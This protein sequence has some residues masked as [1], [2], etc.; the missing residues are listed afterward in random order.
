MACAVWRAPPQPA[1]RPATVRALRPRVW[2][3]CQARLAR[4]R[5]AGNRWVP[6]H[7]FQP[8]ASGVVRLSMAG[9]SVALQPPLADNVLEASWK[10]M[11][12]TQMTTEEGS[13]FLEALCSIDLNDGPQ[14]RVAKNPMP[15]V[16]RHAV[17]FQELESR[18]GRGHQGMIAATLAP[19][20]FLPLAAGGP[21]CLCYDSVQQRAR[22]RWRRSARPDRQAEETRHRGLCQYG[23]R[24]VSASV[25]RSSSRYALCP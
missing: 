19:V 10:S 16:Q 25:V 7:G 9:R 5:A 15:C 23:G 2:A 17:I 12:L 1:A 21:T 13:H 24:R 8:R 11:S 14:P 22:M 20:N 3:A 6:W 18:S 4:T